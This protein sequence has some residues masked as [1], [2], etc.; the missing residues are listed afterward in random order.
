MIKVV[1]K[2]FIKKDKVEVFKNVVP[3]LISETRKE[4]GCIDYKLFQDTADETAF[5]FVEE[6]KSREDLN[7]HMASPHFT[8]IIPQIAEISV[9]EMD[10]FVGNLVL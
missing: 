6:W 4:S 2:A 9:K 10:V 7:L 3:T 1:A 5:C 8:R